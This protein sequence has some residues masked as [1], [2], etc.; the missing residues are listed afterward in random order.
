METWR[1]FSTLEHAGRWQVHKLGRPH[2]WSVKQFLASWAIIQMHPPAKCPLNQRLKTHTQ[3]W[4]H[5]RLKPMVE[6]PKHKFSNWM[7]WI[8]F[9]QFYVFA[10]GL[11]QA[12][13]QWETQFSCGWNMWPNQPMLLCQMR[14]LSSS[15]R[16]C[17]ALLKPRSLTCWIPLSLH[18]FLIH[19]KKEIRLEWHDLFF[20][21]AWCLLPSIFMPVP[22]LI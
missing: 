1:T 10:F 19:Q 21:T 12:L 7:M 13:I 2:N 6:K 18:G 5:T 4:L 17:K 22:L 9:N 14:R 20:S 16:E 3:A 8:L 11:F 15:R